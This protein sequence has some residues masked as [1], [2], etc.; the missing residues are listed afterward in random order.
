MAVCTAQLSEHK[1]KW[2]VNLEG[3]MDETE[4]SPLILF[5][6]SALCNQFSVLN[7]PLY[8]I[9]KVVSIFVTGQSLTQYNLWIQ[10]YVAKNNNLHGNKN[11]ILKIMV[12]S[13]WKRIEW[14]WGKYTGRILCI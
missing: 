11:S 5:A 2:R 14:N 4:H 7:L 8:E 3:K 1:E 12:T 13:G 10:T 6:S 9:H